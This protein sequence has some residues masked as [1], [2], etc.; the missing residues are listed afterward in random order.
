M[1]GSAPPL[2]REKHALHLAALLRPVCDF[3][4]NAPGSEA[5]GADSASLP[6]PLARALDASLDD[7]T[8]RTVAALIAGTDDAPGAA[9]DALD[10]AET[11]AASTD[12]PRAKA[13]ETDG[14]ASAPQLRSLAGTIAFRAATNADA[15][16]Q[17]TR[18]LPGE[19]AAVFPEKDAN[20]SAGD[21]R[22]LLD[23]L[24]DDVERLDLNREAAVT[25]LTALLRFYGATLPAAARAGE[26][27]ASVR[28]VP[29]G[30]QARTTL[31]L[32]SALYATG[33][34]EALRAARRGES[35]GALCR[36]VRG[37]I[38]GIQDFIFRVAREGEDTSGVA[39]RLR[40]RSFLV[41]LVSQVAARALARRLGLPGACVL[42]CGGGSFSALLPA[43]SEAEDAVRQLR[44]DA[45]RYVLRA[46]RGTLSVRLASQPLSADDFSDFGAVY[47]ETSRALNEEK[48]REHYPLW[49]P[50][51]FAPAESSGSGLGKADYQLG[52]ALPSARALTISW[53]DDG[54]GAGDAASGDALFDLSLG[55]LGASVSL[56]ARP[57]EA[58]AP[59]RAAPVEVVSFNASGDFL[60]GTPKP[61]LAYRF[62]FLAGDVPTRG[63][64]P[65]T[66]EEIANLS[67]GVERLGVLKMDVDHLG[68]VFGLGMA[69]PDLARYATLSRQFAHFFGGWL[70][71]RCRRVSAS[72]T[73]GSTEA[74]DPVPDETAFYTLYA[75]GDDLFVIGPWDATLCLARELAGDF[76]RFGAGNP[77]LSV[78]G[79]VECTGPKRPVPQFAEDVE[80]ALGSAKEGD[81]DASE[82]ARHLGRGGRLRLFG[83]TLSWEE[84]R[85]AAAYGDELEAA[86]RDGT[87]SKSFLH[88]LRRLHT[89]YFAGRDEPDL[90]WVPRFHYQ[91]SRTLAPDKVSDLRLLEQLP[92]FMPQAP[93]LLS[94]VDLRTR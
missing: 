80:E 30:V 82:A 58:S 40:G 8:R 33:D 35:G 42:Y 24:L 34:A 12:A 3:L 14:N 7:D 59:E 5:G 46:T 72:I 51:F 19:E 20:A 50:S 71:E 81:A 88:F 63:S 66:F 17:P 73:D 54:D 87:L 93:A 86:V 78:S 89:A 29:L 25:T 45:S 1:P 2:D 57:A 52:Q 10:A 61:E 32:A 84:A 21:Q 9:A 62:Q 49:S 68:L 11:L 79:A 53:D 43:T 70:G 36:F 94:P 77:N 47:R 76:D 65:L 85:A 15:F 28:D 27:Q 4:S 37:D 16:Y 18:L 39:R 41:A 38:G 56:L 23:A 44:E 64:Q 74:S 67:T 13:N 48:K 91:V 6:G 31:A 26:P 90:R 83:E 60:P 69:P 75:G 92:D 22:A 55:A